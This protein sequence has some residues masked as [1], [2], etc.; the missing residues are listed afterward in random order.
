MVSVDVKQYLKKLEDVQ[1]QADPDPD[2]DPDIDPDPDPDIDPDRFGV[3]SAVG[4][5]AW[6]H[7]T[8]VL[9]HKHTH[10]MRIGD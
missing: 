6:S 2:P 10:Q 4:M 5:A 9:R 8:T 3:P 7:F 1:R